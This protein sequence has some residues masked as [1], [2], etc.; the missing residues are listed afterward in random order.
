MCQS[1]E[2]PPPRCLH[3]GALYLL[4]GP[5]SVPFLQVTRTSPVPPARP[6]IIAGAAVAVSSGEK[7]QVQLGP[8]VCLS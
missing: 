7:K 5:I 3:L 4:L 1:P 8:A 2:P 6:G